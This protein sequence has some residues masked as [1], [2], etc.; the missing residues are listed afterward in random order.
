MANSNFEYVRTFEMEDKIIP[1]VWIVVRIDGKVSFIRIFM[2][3]FTITTIENS[4]NPRN[5]ILH[6]IV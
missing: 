4:P 3:E 2:F 5:H 1:N 6:P